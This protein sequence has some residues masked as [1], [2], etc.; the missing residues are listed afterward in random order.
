MRGTRHHPFAAGVCV[1]AGIN[2][3]VAVPMLELRELIK[4]TN[5][6]L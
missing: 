1:L 5:A 6:D 2:L 3:R 4:E